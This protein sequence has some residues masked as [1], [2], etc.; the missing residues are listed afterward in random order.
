M[1]EYY[2][3]V[4]MFLSNLPA[5]RLL[6]CNVGRLSACSRS[7]QNISWRSGTFYV[8]FRCT[9]AQLRA[10]KCLCGHQTTTA[11]S[12]WGLTRDLKWVTNVL[13]SK[14]VNVFIILI[15]F[16]FLINHQ[17]GV[18]QFPGSV[19]WNTPPPTAWESESLWLS[20]EAAWVA[21]WLTYFLGTSTVNSSI[22]PF[23]TVM[24]CGVASLWAQSL[25]LCYLYYICKWFAQC[26]VI[27]LSVPLCR[28]PR[29]VPPDSRPFRPTE[30]AN[31]HHLR[32][33]V[34]WRI[35]TWAS[36]GDRSVLRHQCTQEPTKNQPRCTHLDMPVSWK[37]WRKKRI[38]G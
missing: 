17:R 36:P 33:E 30:A 8:A 7:G 34:G 20:R 12:R 37:R 1:S 25:A 22:T 28:W 4:C 10:S 13:W 9:L 5:W 23:W 32:A 2:V 38:L 16:A 31:Q 6:N 26:R 29:A 35:S 14:Y 11:Y 3:G 27:F 24:W 15:V 21:D 19:W 18:L